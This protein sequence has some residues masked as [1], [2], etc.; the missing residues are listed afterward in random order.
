MAGTPWT[1]TVT[2]STITEVTVTDGT[3]TVT[4]QDTEITPGVP[5]FTTSAFVETTTVTVSATG[6]TSKSVVVGTSTID[7]TNYVSNITKGSVNY[8]LKDA[9]ATTALASKAATDLS[10]VT[11]VGTS[12]SA[13]W[14][15]PSDTY[16]ALTPGASG[17]TYQA[18]ANGYFTALFTATGG[19]AWGLLST[20]G[21]VG[22][23]CFWPTV[24]GGTRAHVPILKSQLLTVQYGSATLDS[25]VFTYAEGSKSE[26]N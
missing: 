15:M 25:L 16:E 19:D 1:F 3:T 21:Q 13:G 17:A 8:V 4:L 20:P 24:G 26:A 9:N 14:A 5:S 18:P 6:Y 12:S 11:A 10:N 22:Q 2:P 23:H 7:M